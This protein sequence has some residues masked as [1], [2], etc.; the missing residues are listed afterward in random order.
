MFSSNF[1]LGTSTAAAQ[2]ETAGAHPWRGLR[3]LDGHVF[4]RTT[5]HEQRRAEDAEYIARLGTVY[6][7]G[8]DWS[9][10]QAAPGAPFDP[11]VVR[12]YRDFFTDLQ[13]R[14]VRLMFVLHHFCHP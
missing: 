8:V 9:R 10:L 13:R 5:D 1:F 4:E 6:R 12:E 14:G 3:A 7:C 2:V 11:E